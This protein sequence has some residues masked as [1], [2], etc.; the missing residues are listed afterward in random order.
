MGL[1]LTGGE[2]QMNIKVIGLDLAKNVFQVHG[3]DGSGRALLRRQLKR[4]EVREFF[5]KLSP[6]L[7][8]MEACGGAHYWAREMSQLGHRVKLINPKYVKPFVKTNKNDRA[9]AEAIA[10]AASRSRTPEVPVK[11]AWQQDLQSLHRVRSE[12]MRERVA[13]GNQM[14]GLLAE[15]GIVAA[16]GVSA[17]RRAIPE[18][19]EDA[20]NGLSDLMRELIAEQY[21]HWQ[22]LACR[23]AEYQRKLRRV[24]REHKGCVALMEVPGIGVLGATALVAQVNNARHLKNGRELAAREGLVPSHSGTGGKARLGHISKRGDGY[25]RTLLVHGAR[26][27]LRNAPRKT[28]RL[29]RWATEVMRRRGPNVAAVALANKMA[30]ISWA[31]LARGE[32]YQPQ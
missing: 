32:R 13:L 1:E 7:V 4:R 25:I 30:R 3:V 23:I 22:A 6:T 11:Q 16:K 31:L 21:E 14:R 17:L 2:E 27:V 26:A 18:I 8:G 24:A 20:Q 12:L 10:E 28:D 9:D 15:Y 29:S 19:L 5:A